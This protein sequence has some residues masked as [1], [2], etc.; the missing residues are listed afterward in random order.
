MYGALA[1]VAIAALWASGSDCS[2]L[3]PVL[4]GEGSGVRGLGRGS[5]VPL[6]PDPSPPKRGRGEIIMCRSPC[7]I[8]AL[9]DRTSAPSFDLATADVAVTSGPLDRLSEDWSLALGGQNPIQAKASQIIGLRR[10]NLTVPAPPQEEQVILVNGDQIPG[11]LLQVTGERVR[12]RAQVGVEQELTLPL[13]AISVLWLTSPDDA[14]DST[15]VR[16]RLASERRKR[17]TLLFRN[18][19]RVDGMLAGFEG[20]TV[21]FQGANGKP[22]QVERANVAAIA[23]NTELAR[24]LRQAGIYGRAILANGC[25]LSLA[26]VHTDGQMLL[27]KTLFKGSVRVPLDQVRAL[28]WRQGCAVYLSDSNPK[29]YECTPFLDLQWPYARDAGVA[30]GEIR[31]GGSSY[32]K[33][34]GMH[35]GSRL[36]YDLGGK[37]R[38]F[39]ASVGLDDRSRQHGSARLEIL[40]D[41]KAQDLGPA[42]E[43]TGAGQARRIRISIA[44]ARELRLGVGFGPRGDVQGHVD[45]ADARLIK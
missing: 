6:T 8:V 2:P 43:L 17:D 11:S 37:F 4:R 5:F 36:T 32:D 35:S 27:G 18:G 26:S 21:R 42:R 9:G 38:W 19:D 24:P 10:T 30:G 12:F 22:F 33:G 15:A 1:I 7:E 3:A 20:E 23:L 44:G 16:R 39:E 14:E 31:L 45:W 40:V 34:I 29:K 28:D 13:S 41:G 25:R